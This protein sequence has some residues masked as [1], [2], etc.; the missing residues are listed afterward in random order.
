MSLPPPAEV[1]AEENFFQRYPVAPVPLSVPYLLGNAS[2]S[3]RLLLLCESCGRPCDVISRCQR[4]KE[5][6]K[7]PRTCR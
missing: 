2:T 6:T 1:V 7:N 5:G 4:R 3:I